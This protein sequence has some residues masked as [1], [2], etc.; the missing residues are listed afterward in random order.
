VIVVRLEGGLGNQLFQYCH[1]LAVQAQVGGRLVLDRRLIRDDPSKAK[2]LDMVADLDP[3][4][5]TDS[6][7]C[8]VLRAYAWVA[9]TLEQSRKGSPVAA[10]QRLARLGVY[11]PFTLRH[12]ELKVAKLPY[13]FLHG[14]FMS[15]RYFQ[16]ALS[17]VQSCIDPDRVLGPRTTDLVARIGAS[18]SVA[19]HIRRGDY[20]HDQWREKLHVCTDDY[21]ARAIDI[22]RKQVKEPVFFVFSNNQE[23]TQWIRDNYRFLPQETVFVPPGSSDIEHFALMAK[24]RHF[25]IANSTYSWWASY[26]SSHPE[27]VTVAPSPWNRGAWDMTDLYITDWKLVDLDLNY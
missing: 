5:L 24:C 21:Y 11:H 26:L 13:H 25:I 12:V 6:L 8:S 7:V 14:N 23:D 1:G 10:S 27:K 2:A 22:I 20:L 4:W 9:I 3:N 17:R 19:I 15:E 16:S 18:N